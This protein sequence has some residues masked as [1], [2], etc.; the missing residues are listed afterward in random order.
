MLLDAVLDG[1]LLLAI[2]I[3]FAFLVCSLSLLNGIS[4]L[5]GLSGS[6]GVHLSHSFVRGVDD[7]SFFGLDGVVDALVHGGLLLNFLQFIGDVSLLLDFS[8]A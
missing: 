5:V 6:L 2:G 1:T 3:L 4:G 8:S 7:G